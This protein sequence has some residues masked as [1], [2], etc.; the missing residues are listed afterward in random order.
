M[1]GALDGIHVLEVANYLTGPFAAMLLADQ[2]AEVIKVEPRDGGDPF[3]G[4]EEHGYSSNFR[5][6][7]RNKRS[8]TL[9]LQSDLGRDILL[10]LAERADVLIEN[11]RPGV[12]TRLGMDYASVA[13]RNPRIIY[14]SISGF[15]DATP[16]SDLPG[17]DTIG[18]ARSGLLSLM[19][20]LSDPQPVGISLSDHVTGLY[21]AQGI[22]SALF[23][24]SRT[25]KG[26]EVK[27][28]LLQAGVSFAQEAASRY[29]TTGKV[30]TR[31]TR[32]RSAQVFAFLA[33]DGLPF[34]IHLSSPPKFWIGLTKAIDR[35]DLQTD[36]RFRD[37]PS[38]IR[39]YDALREILCKAFA[40]RPR[41]TWLAQLQE[42]DVPCS[43]IQSMADVFNDPQV[44]AMDMP[45]T[46]NH[47]TMGEI[48]LSGSGVTLSDHPA[49]YRNAPP[50]LGEH[51]EAILAEID[52]DEAARRQLRQDK[53]I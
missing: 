26:Q 12:M 22:L 8:M 45:V 17:Y 39:N 49:S 18:Q 5:C 34:V 35:T 19:T 44:R 43:P 14:C 28:S 46:F 9:D 29:F 25:G 21:A 32:V 7:N 23:A 40:S 13:K 6:V 16:A 50:L 1:A 10:R 20:D 4:W 42:H 31:Q 36:E 38:R 15:G 52:Y 11:H 27:T 30:P 3:R 51:T 33:G 37:R 47:P 48:R 24:R 41:E 53:V 2:G